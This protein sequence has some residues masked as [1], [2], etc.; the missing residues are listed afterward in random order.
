MLNDLFEDAS[1]AWLEKE[2]DRLYQMQRQASQGLSEV[3]AELM[4]RALAQ[5]EPKA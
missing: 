4:R 5:K 2:R 1:V 3:K